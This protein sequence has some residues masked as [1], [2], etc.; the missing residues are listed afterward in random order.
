MTEETS[1]PGYQ[2]LQALRKAAATNGRVVQASRPI[3][4]YFSLTQ[5]LCAAFHR[6]VDDRQVDAAYVYGLRLANLAIES[7]PRHP[8]WKQP[9]VAKE[10]RRLTSQV[11][12]VLSRMELLKQRITYEE[13]LRQQQQ[14]EEQEEKQKLEEER[15]REQEV[16]RKRIE[17]A[18]KR[19]EE[20]RQRH[21]EA[22]KKE[23]EQQVAAKALQEKQQK[24]EQIQQSAMAKLQALQAK[25]NAS[26]DTQQEGPTPQPTP[27]SPKQ[28][29]RSTR[30]VSTE[31]TAQVSSEPGTVSS[32]SIS[33]ASSPLPAVES[34]NEVT[35]MAESSS[36]KLE[37]KMTPRSS[38]EQATIDLLQRAIRSQ[39][40]RME[41][42]EKHQIPHLLRVVKEHFKRF[43]METGEKDLKSKDEQ[44]RNNPHRRAA[45]Q[46]LARKKKLDYQL[47][48]SKAAIFQMETQIFMLE[49]A[50]EDRQVQTTLN[51]ASQAMASLQQSAKTDES[52][53]NF[54]GDLT[55]ALTS[56]N[57][58]PVLGQEEEEELLDELN[59]WI[60][61]PEADNTTGNPNA[62]S[63]LTDDDMGVLSLPPGLST[64]LPTITNKEPA[65]MEGGSS[66]TESS[67]ARDLMKAV[68]GW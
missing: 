58:M 36:P 34:S 59:E 57:T 30:Q 48:T 62:T 40:K 44:S 14:R 38:K 45:V 5:R 35:P 42:L 28:S 50:M 67:S 65:N 23:Q 61:S 15:K 9:H 46:C 51:E 56:D 17:E 3:A 33:S 55:D 8:E 29:N 21:L 27:V 52:L 31:H 68:L 54:A 11:D 10:R 53:E 4:E 37:R 18:H 41:K 25:S 60:S 47:D 63:A 66:Q 39:E 32:E 43:R 26:V 1:S 19:L 12:Q 20:E 24:K 2:R 7:L 6:A 16:Q 13:M 49:N 64:P 22:Q